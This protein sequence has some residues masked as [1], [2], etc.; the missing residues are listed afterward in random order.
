MTNKQE[1]FTSYLLR[2]IGFVNE[3][4]I[5]EYSSKLESI[6]GRYIV[7]DKSTTYSTLEYSV[8]SIDELLR[9]IES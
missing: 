2:R 6:Y 8:G 4:R 3:D 5:K 7:V 1:I 9:E